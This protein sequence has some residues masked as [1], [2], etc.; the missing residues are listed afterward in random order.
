MKLPKVKQTAS[1]KYHILL[2]VGGESISI[3]ERTE[4]KCIA[5]A[6]AIKERWNKSIEREM[7][8]E[9]N[10]IS[11]FNPTLRQAI[12]MYI[13]SRSNVLSPST[14]RGYRNI[15]RLYYKNYM[16]RRIGD[17]DFQQMV[18]E[19]AI[20]YN[21]KTIKNSFALV[22]AS[23]K[24]YDIDVSSVRLPQLIRQERAWLDTEQLPIF[25]K[26]I[27]GKNCE[28]IALLALH[29]LRRSEILALEKKDIT[30]DFIIVHGAA[31]FDEN[32]NL[33]HKPTNK[34]DS[35]FREIPI[36][37]PKVQEL[38]SELPDG[39]IFPKDINHHK[40]MIRKICREKGLPQV[41]LH[42]LR[43]SFCSLAYA[44]GFDEKTTMALGGWSDYNT[45]RTIYT[46]IGR[47]DIL[48]SVD[49]MRDFYKNL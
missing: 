6:T 48:R 21:P 3:T 4:T 10:R 17:I 18:N 29:S 45:M 47:K 11:Y 26:A 22:K 25:L 12:N 36:M 8:L 44:L 31:V 41:G 37:I 39:R 33:I 42:G 27:Q 30:D 1:G 9:D 32:Y 43:H 16:D 46:H 19:E 5:K 13:D 24:A 23:V 49:K 40:E 7:Q 15:Q 35:S 14:V 34:N 20:E 2:R 38:V 28:L